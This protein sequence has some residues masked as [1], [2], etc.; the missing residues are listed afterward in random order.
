MM[1]RRHVFADPG[2]LTADLL[3][4]RMRLTRRPGA[5][6]ASACFVTGA[7][8]P[9]DDRA[10]FLAAARRIQCP[11]LML[12]GPDTPPRSRA[13]M[14]ALANFPGSKPGCCKAARS[15]WPRSLRPTWLR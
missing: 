6:F 13:E 8:D 15:A 7:L 4:E 12:Y 1:Y 11:I 3:A 5:R 10:S 2:F 9:F 14:E